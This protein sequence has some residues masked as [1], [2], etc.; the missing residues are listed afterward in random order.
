MKSVKTSAPH[1]PLFSQGGREGGRSTR[2]R[3]TIRRRIPFM[4]RP[5]S[6]LVG[7]ETA[8]LGDRGKKME[9]K[10]WGTREGGR[11]DRIRRAE[12]GKAISVQPR[13]LVSA[14]G[15]FE[16][17]GKQGWRNGGEFTCAR[18]FKRVLVARV[19]E[20]KKRKKKRKRMNSPLRIVRFFDSS[21]L[22][23]II[24]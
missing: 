15:I 7:V 8:C 22:L 24:P 14:K 20:K 6:C 19:C 23:G 18:V 12:H 5:L 4:H 9:R 13:F 2:W 10:K 17:G 1:P 11:R 3:V 21:P 16:R